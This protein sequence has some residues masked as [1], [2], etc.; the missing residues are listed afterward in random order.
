MYQSKIGSRGRLFLFPTKSE[1][2]AGRAGGRVRVC[3]CLSLSRAW[4]LSLVT[5][6]VVGKR[7]RETLTSSTNK[8]TSTCRQTPSD[9]YS[10]PTWQQ[11]VGGPI[12]FTR[13]RATTARMRSFWPQTSWISSARELTWILQQRNK[14][15]FATNKSM[16]VRSGAQ[17]GY[18]THTHSAIHRIGCARCTTIDNSAT[19]KNS[20]YLGI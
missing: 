18:Y 13:S 6:T 1:I 8:S 16:R 12:Y 7:S 4:V 15:R 14:G 5:F 19:R 10:R 20:S 9:N 11:D 3:L 17:I 2:S